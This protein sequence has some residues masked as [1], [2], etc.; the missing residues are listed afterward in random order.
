MAH[1]SPNS[2]LGLPLIRRAIRSILD[3]VILSILLASN[4]PNAPEGD[5]PD[6]DDGSEDYD[7]EDL[8]NEIKDDDGLSEKS[9]DSNQTKY[10]KKEILRQQSEFE[11]LE[12]DRKIA[13]EKHSAAQDE[14]DEEAEAKEL[15]KLESLDYSIK[16]LTDD[17][18]ELKDELKDRTSANK[19]KRDSDDEGDNSRRGGPS[20]GTTGGNSEGGPSEGGSSGGVEGSSR[21]RRESAMDYAL[22]IESTEL[23]PFDDIE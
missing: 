1:S 9:D 20:G 16:E 12:A 4:V 8:K 23:P 15:K 19:R 21:V 7:S 10:I 18:L 17:I 2:I 3:M 11:E 5:E 6:D 22:E 13:T 14:S